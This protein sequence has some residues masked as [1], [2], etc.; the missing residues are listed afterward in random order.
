LKNYQ[1]KFFIIIPNKNGLDHFQYSMPSLFSTVYS[2]FTAIVVDDGSDDGS[3]DF[4][5]TNYPKVIILNNEGKPG[6]AGAVNTGVR[7]ALKEGADYIA[8]FNSDIRVLPRWIDL[9]R[10][11]F[12]QF[13]LTGCVGYNEIARECLD[14]F[15][16]LSDVPIKCNKVER[17]SGFLLTYPTNVFRAIGLLDEDYFMYGEDNDFFNRLTRAGYSI[18][19]TSI[20]VW[21]YGAGSSQGGYQ[22][23]RRR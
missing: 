10:D 9:T 3:L 21:H 5:R 14:D 2:N 20:P 12:K 1:P 11:V 16:K 7:L 8:V 15:S 13:P 22:S 4:L 23:S 17:L 19:G 18:L 6:F